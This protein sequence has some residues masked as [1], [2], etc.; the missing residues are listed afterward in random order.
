MN[1]CFKVYRHVCY[2]N[3]K[4]HQQFLMYSKSPF[5]TFLIYTQFHHSP[6]SFVTII[7][8]NYFVYTTQRTYSFGYTYIYPY[9][10]LK[11][12]NFQY[13]S[14]FFRQHQLVRHRLDTDLKCL[15]YFSGCLTWIFLNSSFHCQECIAVLYLYIFKAPIASTEYLNPASYCS[16]TY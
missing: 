16:I 9:S 7:I 13:K 14:H 10:F 11:F 8:I 15:R 2:W 12:A 1:T 6:Y 4:Q 3:H 5:I